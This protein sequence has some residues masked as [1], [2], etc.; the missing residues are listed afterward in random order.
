MWTW[1]AKLSGQQD[2]LRGGR[3]GRVARCPRP[4]VGGAL[5]MHYS[6][7]AR[8]ASFPRA[9]CGL[10]GGAGARSLHNIVAASRMTA[11]GR[12][13]AQPRA[14]AGARARAGSGPGWGRGGAGSG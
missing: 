6:S 11:A 14:A 9:G 10:R 1:G 3:L 12:R 8:V 5:V 4:P 7:A 13:G 2:R